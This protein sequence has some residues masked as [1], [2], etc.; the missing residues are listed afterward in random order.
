MPIMSFTLESGKAIGSL[1]W[2]LSGN[3]IIVGCSDG[4]CHVFDVKVKQFLI[5][6][7]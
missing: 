6:Y 1:C 3:Q 5:F 7:W 4:Q 2:S